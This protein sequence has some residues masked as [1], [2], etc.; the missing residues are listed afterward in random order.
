MDK[1]PPIT[2]FSDTPKSKDTATL[3][4]NN[5]RYI[6]HK[7]YGAG[8]EDMSISVIVALSG[9]KDSTGL[10]S[11]LVSKLQDFP[12]LS[13]SAAY[14]NH[15]IQNKEQQNR[16]TFVVEQITQRLQ[17]PLYIR[18]LS[19]PESAHS[20]ISEHI[21]RDLRYQALVECARDNKIPIIITAHHRE[22]MTETILMRIF[23][24]RGIG[25]L[26]GI[27]LIRQISD[28]PSI[29]LV[30]PALLKDSMLS[31]QDFEDERVRMNLL[32]HN[33]MSNVS[34]IYERNIIR[35]K[36][37]PVLEQYYPQVS[38]KISD[39]SHQQQT[40]MDNSI[41]G[42]SH[43]RWKKSYA[44][45]HEQGTMDYELV[46]SRNIFEQQT[47]TIRTMVLYEGLNKCEVGNVTEKFLQ[48]L[49]ARYLPS[50]ML[51]HIAHVYIFVNTDTITMGSD[52]YHKHSVA[53]VVLSSHNR[54]TLNPIIIDNRYRI[55]FLTSTKN[56]GLSYTI[57]V[58][59]TLLLDTPSK[60]DVIIQEQCAINVRTRL[61]FHKMLQW[62]NIPLLKDDK[63]VVLVAGEVAGGV[64]ILRDEIDNAHVTQKYKVIITYGNMSITMC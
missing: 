29:Y 54:S 15:T 55:H 35:H 43:I 5:L 59:G 48:P 42:S 12:N 33:D 60:H 58:S 17:V 32:C 61:R 23:Q 4:I 38:K 20:T 46:I 36:I 37:I 31:T 19:L 34:D 52:N 57:S 45:L 44:S 49:L 18:T 27:P 2:L 39:L 64:T 53:P 9:G 24:G 21:L 63:G 41:M 8:Y 51:L 3:L 13:V 25:G 6:L 16:E 14:I 7:I 47:S 30:R 11:L 26:K 28:N 62:S 22:D 56:T 40:L 50:Q 10:L 1:Q